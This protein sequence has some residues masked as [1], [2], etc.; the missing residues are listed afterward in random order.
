MKKINRN[1]FL[2]KEEKTSIIEFIVSILT[3]VLDVIVFNLL[4]SIVDNFNLWPILILVVLF[5]IVVFGVIWWLTSIFLC[6]IHFYKGK[7][8]SDYC[9]F[10][11]NLCCGELACESIAK[12]NI[13]TLSKENELKLKD[14]Y[15]LELYSNIVEYEEKFYESGGQE[16]WILSY[17]LNSEI[18]L[19]DG[20]AEYVKNNIQKGIKYY[21]FYIDDPDNIATINRNKANIQN[22]LSNNNVYFIGLKG[23]IHQP[24]AFIL[25]LFGM[26]IYYYEESNYIGYFAIRNYDDKEQIEPIYQKMPI[27]M[28]GKYLDMMRKEFSKAQENDAK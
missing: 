25:C 16:I 8:A 15:S 12:N 5:E 6:E 17:N 7:N 18:F 11:N 14:E 19:Q 21:Y 26:V 13:L 28:V 10:N 2:K 22:A 1:F 3:I 4:G 27:C 9:T 23:F 20:T 24:E